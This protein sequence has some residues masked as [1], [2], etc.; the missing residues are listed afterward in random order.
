MLSYEE[1][2]GGELDGRRTTFRRVA[3]DLTE[4]EGDAMRWV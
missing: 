2:G 4:K 1:G 3:V